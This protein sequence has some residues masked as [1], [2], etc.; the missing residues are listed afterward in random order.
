M[1]KLIAVISVALIA[2]MSYAGMDDPT[3]TTSDLT[4]GKAY[5]N[6]IT[7]RGFL[8]GVYVSCDSWG[9]CS[10]AVTITADG[11]TLFS[12][13]FTANAMYYP[14]VGVHGTTGTALTYFSG[15]TGD[16]NTNTVYGSIPI[17]G[18]VTIVQ[19]HTGTV[20]TNAYSC[21]MIVNK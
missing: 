8:E 1:K 14:K 7:V 9:G 15:T 19:T 10:N 2:G 20:S 17:A 16:R 12:K 4:N 5:T 18:T 13:T 3:V 21:K 6:N 11:Q